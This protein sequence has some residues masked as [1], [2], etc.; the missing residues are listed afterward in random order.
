MKKSNKQLEYEIK[1][2]DPTL[3]WLEIHKYIKG[4]DSKLLQAT[5]DNI[6]EAVRTLSSV[7]LLIAF[8]ITP[9]MLLKIL[10]LILALANTINNIRYE[11]K[12][13]EKEALE[14]EE[15]NETINLEKYHTKE[16]EKAME[17][18]QTEDEIKYERALQKQHTT[19][20]TNNLKSKQYFSK[21]EVEDFMVSMMEFYYEFYKLP[22]YEIEPI[23][24]NTYYDALYNELEKIG[25]EKEYYDICY[26]NLIY[27]LSLSMVRNQIELRIEDFVESL[28]FLDVKYNTYI[29]GFLNKDILNMKKNIVCKL[30]NEKK[31]NVVKFTK[32]I[33]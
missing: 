4:I 18:Q 22:P 23:E 25:R 31:N 15:Q 29:P 13:N 8:F 10:F 27:A 2:L 20:S 33:D 24:W 12:Q 30:L 14:P 19:A 28:K 5:K 3:E 16:Y 26:M 9:S 17:Y 7:V 11:I 6:K 21:Q 32:N 1:N